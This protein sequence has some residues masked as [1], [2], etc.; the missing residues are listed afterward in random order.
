M[1][2]AYHNLLLQTLAFTGHIPAHRNEFTMVDNLTVLIH[3]S[4]NT[5]A[6]VYFVTDFPTLSRAYL[7]TAFLQVAFRDHR[8]QHL[9]VA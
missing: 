7:A 4:L 2:F 1:Y 3:A 6:N 8:N 5:S 9:V